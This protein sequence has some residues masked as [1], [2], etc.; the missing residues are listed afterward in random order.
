MLP[1]EPYQLPPEFRQQPLAARALEDYALCPRR[2]LLSFFV[3]REEERRFHGGPAALHTAVRHALVECH[4]RGGPHLAPV[5][6]LLDSFEAHWQGDLCADSI[7]EQQLHD[8]GRGM[9]QDYHD[10]H[11]GDTVE[12]VAT[13]Q[14]FEAAIEGQAFVAVA[15]VVLQP[16]DGGREVVRFVTARRP[17]DEDQLR[18]DLSAQVLWLLAHEHYDTSPDLPSRVGARV[19]TRAD[20]DAPLR[21]L[22]YSLRQRLAHEVVLSPEQADLARRDL[23]T[24]AARLYREH[25]FAPVKGSQCRYCR[26]RR[27]CPLWQR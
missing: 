5:E 14:R 19:L 8:Q 16:H 12:V 18:A 17:L 21:V 1:D 24:R 11:R 9:L 23:A 2:F 3:G 22:F 4:G 6:S 7:E 10:D 13:D 25:D 26:V 20:T 15:D 27:R